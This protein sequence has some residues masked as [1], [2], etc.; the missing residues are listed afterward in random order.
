MIIEVQGISKKYGSQEVVR[1]VSFSLKKG[2]I[3]GFLRLNGTGKS[4]MLK[5]IQT[6]P[7]H[8][9]NAYSR[10]YPIALA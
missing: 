1:N 4:T 2:E 5:R 6:T 3:A 8:C 9:S 10:P 7:R